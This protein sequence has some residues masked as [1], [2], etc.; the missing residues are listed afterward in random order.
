MI[1]KI[2]L[3]LFIYVTSL[4]GVFYLMRAMTEKHELSLII[5]GFIAAAH[6][7]LSAVGGGIL[8]FEHEGS[9]KDG[10]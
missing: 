9:K 1:L 3:I 4:Q 6:F 2:V 10:K 5:F 8:V 7:S